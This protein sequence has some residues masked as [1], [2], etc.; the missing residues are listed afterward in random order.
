MQTAEPA[1]KNNIASIREG[2]GYSQQGFADK[3]GISG[4]WLNKIEN[5]HKRPSLSTMLRI[6]EALD[7]TLNDIF[8][9]SDWSKQPTGGETDEDTDS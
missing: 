2:K 7:V 6:A 4:N 8:L 9:D 3:L 5:G 1:F